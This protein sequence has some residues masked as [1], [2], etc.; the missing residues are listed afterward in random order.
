MNLVSVLRSSKQLMEVTG[1][2]PVTSCLQISAA[3][4]QSFGISNLRL[5]RLPL[6]G[7][8]RAV[9]EHFR[10]DLCTNTWRHAMNSGS[11]CS[12]GTRV[13]VPPFQQT[14]WF[15]HGSCPAKGR[16]LQQR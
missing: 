6:F 5:G 2:E 3:A 8:I 4:S 12:A 14:G 16:L 15:V 7:A 13:W 9:S 11:S 1:I 10:Y